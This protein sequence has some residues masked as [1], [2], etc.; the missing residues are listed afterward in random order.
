MLGR[1]AQEVCLQGM[2]CKARQSCVCMAVL[3]LQP[4]E[5]WRHGRLMAVTAAEA[6]KASQRLSAS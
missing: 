4:K 6:A 2:T 3:L 5:F 1:N